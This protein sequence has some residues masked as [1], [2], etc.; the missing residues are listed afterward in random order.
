MPDLVAIR[1]DTKVYEVTITDSAGEPYDLT[2]ADLWF[3]VAGLLE[4]RLNDGITVADVA[5]GVAT[6][7]LEAGDTDS[8]PSRRK[9]YDY[10][11]QV[12]LSNGTVKTPLRGRFVVLPDVTTDTT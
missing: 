7:T 11:L 12:K 4:K 1:G 5:T 8:A 9:V 10:D 6:V 2:G 3:T